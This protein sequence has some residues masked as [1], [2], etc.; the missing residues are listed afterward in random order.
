MFDILIQQAQVVDGSGGPPF[1]ADIGIEG[2]T[3]NAIGEL[4]AAEAR[5]TIEAGELMAT[6]GFIDMHTHSDWTLPGNRRAESKIRQ[7]VTTSTRSA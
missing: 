1:T 3:I 6:P 7:G 4:S 5:T 2:D